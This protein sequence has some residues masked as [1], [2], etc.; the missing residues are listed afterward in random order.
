M[1][2]SNISKRKRKK[3]HSDYTQDALSTCN[4]AGLECLVGGLND[5]IINGNGENEFDCLEAMMSTTTQVVNNPPP[6]LSSAD[7]DEI[8]CMLPSQ[9]HSPPPPPP[10]IHQIPNIRIELARH[11]QTQTLSK[12]L[13]KSCP[14]LRMPSF[15]RWLLDSKLEES[16]RFHSIITNWIDNPLLK[17]EFIDSGKMK[18]KKYGRAARYD[19]PK[20][21]KKGTDDA[22][23]ERERARFDKD[24]KLVL[25]VEKR[26]TSSSSSRQQQQQHYIANN[27]LYNIERD[28]I[29]PYH[30]METDPSCDR[31]IKEIIVTM[32]TDTSTTTR[33]EDNAKEI[34]RELCLRA[35]EACRELH[36][37]EQR[38]G[39]YQ[40]FSWDCGGDSKRRKRDG[41][42]SK[43]GGGSID[44]ILVEWHDD[45]QLCS[46]VYV[47]KKQKSSRGVSSSTTT[48]ASMGSEDNIQH[49]GNS[50]TKNKPKPFVLKINASHYH[51]LRKMFDFTYR[52]S[53]KLLPF[54]KNKDQDVT[55]AFH[56]VLFSLIIRYS[57]LSGGQLLN[58]LRGGGMQGAVHDAVFDCLSNWFGEQQGS[59]TS[60]G[61]EC[62]ASPF[63]SALS[64][65]FSAFP[66]PDLD[67]HFG[68]YG[69][70]FYPT[71]SNNDSIF[72]RP[73]WLEL[74]PPFSPGI[75]TKMAHRIKELLETQT[76]HDL[77]V[78][79]VVII[80]TVRS[81]TTVDE[82]SR[83]AA[84][85][86]N[87]KKKKE[88][89]HGSDHG[90]NTTNLLTGTVNQAAAQSFY[91]LTSSPYCKC[92]IILPPREHGYIE[93]SQHLRPTQFKESQY[94]TS[95]IVLRTKSSEKMGDDK[96]TAELF[97]KELREAFASRH[98]MELA[99]RKKGHGVPST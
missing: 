7:D 97:E 95:V 83:H 99:E 66:S 42:S 73:G 92:H 62:F 48:D 11:L 88:K 86:S 36:H 3:S 58:D 33:D 46:L 64:R 10:G 53:E 24:C 34:V 49:D 2:K 17:L 65:Y 27:I 8:T 22:R 79:Y 16:D 28:A 77:D 82:S 75:M 20:G 52:S 98:A 51:K 71:S 23:H 50:S 15:E 14:T 32:S 25:E 12:F 30:V 4:V 35:A 57:A 13:L 76:K 84:K 19:E 93:G 38:L 47:P 81:S 89:H 70:F 54:S 18:K 55:T 90:G 96:D 45:N 37:L 1:M 9:C 68:S 5:D 31:L 78:T 80:P 87:K 61:T 29:L 26:T 67:G 21:D 41:G 56:A 44:K 59:A 63:N 43:G 72:L 74:N 94:S 60:S 85:A 6:S 40:K 91:Q 39:K 69:D